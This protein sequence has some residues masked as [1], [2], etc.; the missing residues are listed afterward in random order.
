MSELHFQPSE[1]FDIPTMAAFMRLPQIYWPGADAL[2]PQPEQ[3][4]FED[5]LKDQWVWPL[6]CLCDG[7]IIGYIYI[8][9]RS[10]VLGEAHVGFLPNFRGRVAKAFLLYAVD[11]AFGDLGFI[12]LYVTITAD[13]RAAI[14]MAKAC[15]FRVEGRLTNAVT[16]SPEI[17]IGI[18]NSTGLSDLL[19][20]ARFKGDK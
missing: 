19:I 15:G 16:R 9:R 18:A 11:R 8:L 3:V 20:L 4:H 17:N 6:A 13:N 1:Q 10:P 12:K 5:Y 2:S 14:A 7:Y